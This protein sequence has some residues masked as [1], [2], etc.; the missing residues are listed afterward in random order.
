MVSRHYGEGGAFM[1]QDRFITSSHS[2]TLLPPKE[3]LDM[4]YVDTVHEVEVSVL[5][6]TLTIRPLDEFRRAQKL[7]AAIEDV[8]ESRKKA[9]EELAKGAE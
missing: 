9:Y 3:I 7:N 8:I 5:G 1:A 2:T 6:R 4:L